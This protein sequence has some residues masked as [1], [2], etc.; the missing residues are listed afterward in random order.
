MCAKPACG[1]QIVED[2]NE[3]SFHAVANG[4]RQAEEVQMNT[5]T[6][7]SFAQGLSQATARVVH[8]KRGAGN[9]AALAAPANGVALRTLPPDHRREASSDGP[10]TT[11]EPSD[12][13]LR[14]QLPPSGNA[15]NGPVR[16]HL[17]TN[18]RA[19]SSVAALALFRLCIMQR[20]CALARVP[21]YV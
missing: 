19:S 14:S 11:L 5:A 9:R 16:R 4:R 1:L 20:W 7:A 6:I 2:N 17:P 15:T 13:A 3:C 12:R 18:V 10:A 21:D 8:H